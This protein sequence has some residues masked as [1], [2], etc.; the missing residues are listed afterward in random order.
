ML[1][2]S[3]AL[4]LGFLH[5]L[6]ADHLM[7]IAALSIG[8]A[9]TT[10]AGRRSRALG[11]AVRFAVGHALLLALGAGAL[12]ILG[13]S[14]PLSFERGGEILGGVIL[15][16]LGGAGLW[17]VATGQVYAHA[18]SHTQSAAGWHLHFGNRDGH[19]LATAHSQLPTIVGA[20]FA[21]SSL[22]ALTLLAPFGDSVR[23][24]SLPMLLGL[25]LVFA[26]GILISMSLFGVAFARLMS[27]RAI[28]RMG[29][30]SASVPPAQ[31][32]SHPLH[33]ACSG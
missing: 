20:A 23:T 16:A 21:V 29:T 31:L 3:T 28:V 4:L 1:L 27:T 12:V 9:G 2:L 13:W 18:H 10:A 5:G 11:I 19:P 25:I 32:R 7:G 6:G 14:L 17:G 30:A 22:R 8:S 26:V 33:S 15:I 24:T